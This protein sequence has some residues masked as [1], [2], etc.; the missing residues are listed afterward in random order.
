MNSISNRLGAARARQAL[1]ASR[2]PHRGELERASSTSNEIYLSDEH[3]IRINHEA[4]QRLRRESQLY[5]HLPDEHWTPRLTAIGGEVGADF[6]IVERKPGAPLAHCW[7]EMSTAQ[8]K[9]SIEQLAVGLRAIHDTPTPEDVPRLERTPHLLDSEAAPP[10]RPLLRGLDQLAVDPNLDP[11]IISLAVEYVIEHWRELSGV[12]DKNLIH[13]DLTFENVLWDGNRMS[14]IIDFEWCRGGPADLDLDVLLRCCALPEDHVAPTYSE[15]TSADDYADVP[16][17]LAEAYPE[18]FAHPD[19]LERLTLYALSFEVRELL[20]ART[21]T[22]RRDLSP[23]HPYSRLVS[24]VSSGGHVSLA[25]HRA[26]V[27]V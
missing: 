21:D 1:R 2:L 4:S 19:I 22:V 15:R 8:R 20:G 6:L 5:P 13:G 10:V 14:A 11:G 27:A 7:S 23:R 18:L 25:L 24:L 12:P 16:M 17:W 9:L 3:V 26:G